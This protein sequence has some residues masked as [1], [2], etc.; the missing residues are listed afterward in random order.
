[1]LHRILTALLLLTLG[2]TAPATA[3]LMTMEVSGTFGAGVLL[4]D[5]TSLENTPFTY[6]ALF[7]PA[8]NTG[9]PPGNLVSPAS[10]EFF[11]NSVTYTGA[12]SHVWIDATDPVT[13][14]TPYTVG[15][16]NESLTDWQYFMGNYDT[17]S[18][19]FNAATPVNSILS[20]TNVDNSTSG[21]RLTFTGGATLSNLVFDAGASTATFSGVS[22][23]PEP[24]TYA[25][26]CISLGVV[27][28]ARR[29]M[30][31]SEE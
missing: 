16:S 11:I 3:S 21:L 27:G 24:S 6:R 13:P 28:Y 15:L 23:V 1:M 7:D 19:P 10:V 30:V 29:K 17:I 18:T 12:T 2:V 31:K 5:A 9:A 22:A 25:L 20:G 4:N 26:L 14:S 8:V